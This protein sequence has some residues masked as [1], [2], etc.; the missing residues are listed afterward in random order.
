MISNNN[1]GVEFK[2]GGDKE[3]NR[4]IDKNIAAANHFKNA[5]GWAQNCGF[6]YY[7]IKKTNDFESVR[8]TLVK[9]SAKPIVVEVFTTDADD[10]KG[11]SLVL[12]ANDKRT[13][14]RKIFDKLKRDFKIR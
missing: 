9:P 2:L 10:Y 11:Y 1:G 3:K 14:T 12:K 7:K 6:D 5:E 4:F 8:N 13:F